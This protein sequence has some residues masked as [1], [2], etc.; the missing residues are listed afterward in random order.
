MQKM[1]ILLGSLALIGLFILNGCDK[2][3]ATPITKVTPTPGITASA[4]A[5]SKPEQ[6]INLTLRHSLIKNT[7]KNSLNLLKEAVK[8]TEAAVPNLHIT[9][10]GVDENSNRSTKLKEEMMTGNPPDIFEL[11]GG[12]TDAFTYAKAGKL[13][14]L[15]PILD[16]LEK[17]YDFAS[18]QNFTVDGKIYGLPTTGQVSG[19]FYNKKIFAELGVAPPL[20]YAEFLDICEQAKAKGITPLAFAAG[21][22]WVPTMLMNSLLVRTAGVEVLR[23][24]VTGKAKWTDPAIVDAFNQYLVLVSKGYFTEKSS[25]LKYVDQQNQFKA[26]KA[27]MLFDGSWLYADLIDSEG[28]KV[29]ND[30]GF[31][32]LPDMGSAG[33]G[34]INGGF[35]QGYGFSANLSD[36]QKEAVKVFIRTMFNDQMQKRQLLEDGSFPSM[37]F[38]DDTGVPPLVIDIITAAKASVGTFESFDEVIQK[39]VLAQLE[40]GMEQLLEGKITV[41]QLTGKLQMVQVEANVQR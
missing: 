11:F 13:L 27:A 1:K 25:G 22:T 19:I 34:W 6:A 37:F 7:S 32:R 38:L 3:G 23:D 4:I 40:A 20:T 33:N 2:G 10:E 28:S 12:E 18:L 17:Q 21:D 30:V 8:E 14:D 9:L 39:R 31:F 24:L 26:G 5:S 35:N 41:L 16:E 29:S 36:P 15:T